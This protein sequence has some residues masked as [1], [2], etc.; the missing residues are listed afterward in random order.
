[1]KS[2]EVKNPKLI[3]DRKVSWKRIIWFVGLTY[4]ITIALGIFVYQEG[5]KL[6]PEYPAIK[7]FLEITKG[8]KEAVARYLEVHPEIKESDLPTVVAGA[9][10][11]FIELKTL[12]EKVAVYVSQKHLAIQSFGLMMLFPALVAI[13]LRLVFKDGFKNSGFRFGKFK[14]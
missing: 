4:L 9:S 14:N 10:G 3:I 2:K 7:H 1:M 13:I 8:Q 6:D 5:K 11:Q 12:E